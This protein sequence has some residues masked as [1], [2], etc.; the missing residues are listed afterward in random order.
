[1]NK[2]EVKGKLAQVLDELADVGRAVDTLPDTVEME[3]LNRTITRQEVDINELESE[4]DSLKDDLYEK[5]EQ[6]YQRHL[7][8]GGSPMSWL[9]DPERNR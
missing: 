6:P 1:M 7:L 3:A 8:D 2:A 9:T 5:N 4:L